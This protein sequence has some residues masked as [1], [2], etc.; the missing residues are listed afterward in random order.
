MIKEE[1]EDD[2]DTESVTNSLGILKVDAEKGK[3]MYFGDSHWHTVLADIAEVKS[4]FAN[5]ARELDAQYKKVSLSN[6]ASTMVGPGLLFGGHTQISEG[7]LRAGLLDRRSTEKLVARYFNSHD[8]AVH[9]LHHPTFSKE[10]QNHFR[11]PSKTCIV[12]IGALYAIMSLAMQGYEKVGDE[13]PEWKGKTQML[14]SEYRTR[15]VQCLVLSDYTKPV[16]YTLETL[17]LYVHGEHTSRMDAD[18]GIWSVIAVIIRLAMRQGYHRDSRHFPGLSPF[19]GEM[20][21]RVWAWLRMADVMF[22]FQ[23]ALPGMIKSLDCD[24][25]LPRNLSDEQLY[26]DMKELPP[27]RPDDE[28]TTMLYMVTKTRLC[29][30]FGEAIEQVNSVVAQ[31]GYDRVMALD[32]RLREFHS[33]LPPSLRLRPL[34]ESLS[35]PARVL[36]ERYTLDILYQKAICVLHRK[37]LARARSHSRY[38]HSRRACVEAGM[39]ILRHH[40]T[41]H[42][43]S[44]I[45]GRMRA[46]RWHVSSLTKSDYLLGAMIVCL[47]LHYDDIA[48]SNATDPFFWT[49]SQR[50]DM[51]EALENS[52]SIFALSAETSMESFKASRILTIMLDKLRANDSRPK[53]EPQ[54]TSEAFAAFDDSQPEHSAAMTLGMLQSGGMTPNTAALFNNTMPLTPG[55]RNLAMD[56]DP[57]ISTGMTPNFSMDGMV[58]GNAAGF[59]QSPFGQVF[60]NMTGFPGMMDM[61]SNLDW[62]RR[63]FKSS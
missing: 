14:A 47:D 51:Y 49:A 20:R 41:L 13:P 25:E 26:E 23:L 57:Q 33:T 40:A 63:S 10:L 16:K 34:E 48:E 1:G 58:G 35:D 37:Y 42:R 2:S 60:G 53:P 19:Q 30:I 6:P 52:R 11:D 29:I 43:E 22:S 44:Q 12:W 5:H 55:G 50:K 24:T 28:S 17:L 3:S 18:V 62:V 32:N 38:A 36:M 27:A 39:Q 61:P 59:P 54:S 8:T 46:V 7:E 31:T 56:I 4:Y 21:R 45:G 9:L 15:T